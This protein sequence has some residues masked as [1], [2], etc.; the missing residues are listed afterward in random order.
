M[1]CFSGNI[2]FKKELKATTGSIKGF[3]HDAVINK[4]HSSVLPEVLK[5]NGDQNFN[6]ELICE[7]ANGSFV[8]IKLL[9]SVLVKGNFKVKCL[10]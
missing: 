6:V 9:N 10:I 1:L 7:K 3:S 2:S 8:D 4:V 5:K